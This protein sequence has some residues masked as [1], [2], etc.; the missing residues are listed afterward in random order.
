M[1][2]SSFSESWPPSSRQVLAKR[3]TYEGKSSN[4]HHDARQARSKSVD[5][6]SSP[7]FACHFFVATPQKVDLNAICA[8][9]SWPSISRL[10][11]VCRSTASRGN[12]SDG[13][14]E[15]LYRRHAQQRPTC[16]R[17][18]STFEKEKDLQEHLRADDPCKIRDATDCSSQSISPA[19]MYRL[20]RRKGQYNET[21][22]NKWFEIWHLLFP[23]RKRPSSPCKCPQ[24]FHD[25]H[26][27]ILDDELV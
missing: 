12:L 27:S 3:A 7:R 20:R 13:Y 1:D 21:E 8:R 9:T 24:S 11:Y 26:A 2:D 16:A 23:D 6:S 19:Q 5:V 4:K 22:V 14:R 25:S 18:A 17:C 10:K 15:H